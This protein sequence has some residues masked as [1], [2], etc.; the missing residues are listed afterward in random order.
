MH[1]RDDEFLPVTGAWLEGDVV[2]QRQFVSLGPI[3]LEMGGRE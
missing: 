1:S 3:D 2:G